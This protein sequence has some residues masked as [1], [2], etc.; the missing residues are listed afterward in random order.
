[1]PHQQN[2]FGILGQNE[3][4]DNSVETVATQVAALTCQSQMTTSTTAN[5]S[6][7]AEQ[8]F[9]HLASRQNMMHKNM[10]Q[11]IAQVNALSFDQSNTGRGHIAGTNFEGNG[12]GG[13]GRR[14]HPC[15]AQNNA[16]NGGQFGTSGGFSL[17]TGFFAPNPPPGGVM[18]Y[19]GP[20][21][22]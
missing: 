7:R 12:G 17:A 20:S 19:E 18:P 6:Q 10:H 2:A 8:Q 3:L 13:Q 16:S 15:G 21:Q 1:M 14:Q 5:A 11:I 9:A 22:G 4:D